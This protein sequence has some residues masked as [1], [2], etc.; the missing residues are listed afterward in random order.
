MFRIN[1]MVPQVKALSRQP[2]RPDF[3]RRKPQWKRRESI[4]FVLCS[5]TYTIKIKLNKFY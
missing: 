4:R 5:H 3:D 1:K 2:K